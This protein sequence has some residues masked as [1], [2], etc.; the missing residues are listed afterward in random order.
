MKIIDR[1]TNKPT[2]YAQPLHRICQLASALIEGERQPTWFQVA[3]GLSNMV[4][5]ASSP[6]NTITMPSNIWSLLSSLT[7]EPSAA[8]S[9]NGAS[10]SNN[11]LNS[12]GPLTRSN[13]MNVLGP[14]A[15]FISGTSAKDSSSTVN[16]HGDPQNKEHPNQQTSL[17]SSSLATT[18]PKLALAGWASS[19]LANL[20]EYFV[21]SIFQSTSRTFAKRKKPFDP[22]ETF[23]D[24]PASLAMSSVGVGKQST[25]TSQ[26]QQSANLVGAS[27]GAGKQPPTPC[28]SVEEYISPT[29]ARNYQGAWKYVV[30]IPHEGYFT[31]T[32]Q[33]TSCVNKKCEF[34]DGVCHESP[35]WVSLLVA[36]IYYPNTIF[37]P[38]AGVI[39]DHGNNGNQISNHMATSSSTSNIQQMTNSDQQHHLHPK[40]AHD[41]L[42]MTDSLNSY[43]HNL[44]NAFISAA[45]ELG[46][47][48]NNV[49]NMQHLANAYNYQLMQRNGLTPGN[50]QPV[51]E[52]RSSQTSNI[53][54]QAS[55]PA[56]SISSA[57]GQTFVNQP[58]AQQQQQ[59]QLY[60]QQQQQPQQYH[61]TLL[62]NQQMAQTYSNDYIVA[63]ATAALQQNPN[64]NINDIINSLQFTQKRKKRDVSSSVQR[65]TRNQ[66]NNQMNSDIHRPSPLESLTSINDINSQPLATQQTSSINQY[67]PMQPPISSHQ[68]K[69]SMV[70]SNIGNHVPVGTQSNQIDTS[71][72]QL[73]TTTNS[74]DN[75]GNNN[76]GNQVEC[77]GHDKIGCYVVRVYYDWFLVNGSCK[78]WKTSTGSQ[79]IGTQTSSG[80]SFL[81]RIFTG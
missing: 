80:N 69:S 1:I 8:K 64:L 73:P 60:L 48:P 56:A 32:I 36:E 31:Q 15:S 81:R 10:S 66:F 43:N 5:S 17:L 53:A 29:F 46:W 74:A 18:L 49:N 58:I 38:Q 52:A 42:Q 63:L 50:A 22:L 33:K 44:N 62:S 2:F 59:Q 51:V 65:S 14:I 23:V 71:T 12:N 57:F 79:Q 30:Q 78:C 6:D 20:V 68:Q 28:P 26:Q 70:E 4:S 41:P 75:N 72:N 37:S 39:G 27:F 45:N 77:D 9:N 34:T 35:R 11:N 24:T 67:K 40:S 54:T 19:A 7:Q 13:I 76:S 3:K 47:D 21:P 25:T 16:S 61:N 55:S